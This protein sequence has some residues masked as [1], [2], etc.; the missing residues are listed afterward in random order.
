[1]PRFRPSRCAITTSATLST[2]PDQF[3]PMHRREASGDIDARPWCVGVSAPRCGLEYRSGG[4]CWT[5]AIS[6]TV[7]CSPSCCTVATISAV[8][9]SDHGREK[10]VSQATSPMPAS[11]FQRLSRRCA[12]TGC[13]SATNAPADRCRCGSSCRLLSSGSAIA[14]SPADPWF[15]PPSC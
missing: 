15:R 10:M 3:K 4:R 2:N 7:D 13:R 8:R 1:M 6:I 5:P 9:C 14:A 12:S 11:A